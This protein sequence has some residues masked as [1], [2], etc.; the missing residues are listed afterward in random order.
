MGSEVSVR[1]VVNHLKLLYVQHGIH[2]V[3]FVTP[4]HFLPHITKIVE[5]LRQD[6]VPVPVVY[7]T[8][9]YCS[10]SSIQSSEPFVDIYMPDFKFGNSAV[11]KQLGRAED[12]VDNALPAL[13]EMV[14]QKGPLDVPLFLRNSAKQGVFVR[15]LVIPGF[16]DSSIQVLDL[17]YERFGADLPVHIMSQYWPARSLTHKDLNRRL[18]PEEIRRVNDHALALGFSNLLLQSI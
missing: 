4:D 16:I 1:H 15:H 7:N 12:Y 3:N 5:L 9:G 2:N 17:L 6:Q 13:E 11:A 10:V 14:R 8:S 18:Y